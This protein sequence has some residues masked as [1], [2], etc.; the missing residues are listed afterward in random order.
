MAAAH[1]QD[2]ESHYNQMRVEQKHPIVQLVRSEL[3][4][5]QQSSFGRHQEFVEK[6]QETERLQTRIQEL[7][8]ETRQMTSRIQHLEQI[9]TTLEVEVKDL[10]SEN[11]GLLGTI[12]QLEAEILEASKN[13]DEAGE[14]GGS[15]WSDFGDTDE[16]E[17]KEEEKLTEKTP[18]NT[19]ELRAK[20][21]KYGEDM[22]ELS[23]AKVRLSELGKKLDET[24][25]ELSKY[26]NLYDRQKDQESRGVTETDIK[27]KTAETEC[28]E[29]KK[30]IERLNKLKEEADERFS[31]LSNSYGA[32]LT[33][34]GETNIQFQSLRD[35]KNALE[36]KLKDMEAVIAKKE[37]KIRD[38][39]SEAKRVR[40]LALSILMADAKNMF[41]KGTKNK[42]NSYPIV[43][44]HASDGSKTTI[45]NKHGETVSI[46][47]KK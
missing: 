31:S 47:F 27:L 44:L 1:H 24:E 6:Q 42:K 20:Y 45:A 28:S 4:K 26:R 39:E 17:V 16:V 36:T 40:K 3:T 34:S 41:P 5:T 2:Y 19:E 46:H 32:V 11:A 12:Q 7:G 29:L 23:K 10:K 22:E 14:S 33:K 43:T 30:Q 35:E 15:G 9:Q 13:N 21:K 38:A 8:G 25:K 18:E 37:E